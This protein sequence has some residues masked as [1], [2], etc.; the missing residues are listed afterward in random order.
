M[1]K[2]ERE[3]KLSARGFPALSLREIRRVHAVACAKNIAAWDALMRLH[4]TVRITLER[5][6]CRA[7]EHRFAQGAGDFWWIAT[8]EL[9]IASILAPRSREESDVMPP[10]TERFERAVEDQ[11]RPA[12]RGKLL[13]HE[14]DF[15]R[16]FWLDGGVRVRHGR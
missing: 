3:R 11:L 10:C 4:K 5:P 16:V 2:A 15:R 7:C 13:A 8:D 12:K 1:K 9:D 14:D 6:A